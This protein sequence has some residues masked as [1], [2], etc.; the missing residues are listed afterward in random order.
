LLTIV[1][2]GCSPSSPPA[3]R[4][5][6]FPAAAAPATE[7]IAA[8]A[9]A[10][11]DPDANAF[12]KT[13]LAA[14]EVE[15]RLAAIN[16]LAGFRDVAHL[17][18]ILDQYADT[19]PRIRLAALQA[20]R[21]LGARGSLAWWDKARRDPDA[22]IRKEA[23][24]AVVAF[25]DENA[26]LLMLVAALDDP[27]PL[28]ADAATAALLK[29]G[30]QLVPLFQQLAVTAT[31]AARLRMVRL[32][33]EQRDPELAPSLVWIERTA[34][35]DE[36]LRAEVAR[37]LAALGPV[38]GEMIALG[39]A[40]PPA[41]LGAG[42]TPQPDCNV[43]VRLENGVK[44]RALVL[45]LD[46][47]DNRWPVT[48]WGYAP[49]FNKSDH[50]FTVLA[51]SRTDNLI[52]L[53][54][55]G[56]I[57]DDPWV[58]GGP[59]RYTMQFAGTNGTW[60]GLFRGQ[61]VSGVVQVA[62][63]PPL[64]VTRS[65]PP[66]R[67]QEHPRLGARRADWQPPTNWTFSAQADAALESAMQPRLPALN[68]E[69][70]CSA[71][72]MAQA[73]DTLY[74][75]ASPG[76]RRYATEAMLGMARGLLFAPSGQSTPWH[77]WQGRWRGGAGIAAIVALND[78]APFPLTPPSD[79]PVTECAPSAEAPDL[80]VN[81]LGDGPLAQWR[82]VG[83]ESHCV[84]RVS[85]PA[86]VR[87]K[88]AF[89][90]AAW[91]GDSHLPRD[92]LVALVPGAYLLRAVVTPGAR[93]SNEEWQP[94]ELVVVTDPRHRRAKWRAEFARWQI[95]GGVSPL[96]E[97][98]VKLAEINCRRY[99]EWA[100]GDGGFNAEKEK[101]TLCTVAEMSP[102]LHAL[103]N[104]LGRNLVAGSHAEW[105]PL[106][107]KAGSYG[108]HGG[109]QFYG[110][111]EIVDLMSQPMRQGLQARTPA[112]F[113]SHGVRDRQKTGYVFRNGWR[114]DAEDIFV[115]VEG[116]GQHLRSAH[117]SFD[118]GTF[119]LFGLGAAWAVYT[120]YGRDAPRDVHNV[121]LFPED[122]VD[123]TLPARE[124]HY[125]V[126][127][128]GSGTVS[129]DMND[130]YRGLGTETG[131]LTDFEARLIPA[132]V[133]DLGIKGVRAVAADFTGNSGAPGIVLVADKITGGGKRVW[134]MHLAPGVTAE[135]D[136]R[137]FTLRSKKTA[138]TVRGTFVVPS[139]VQLAGGG[140]LTA[141]GRSDFVV[142]MTL[143]RGIP[144]V[145]K[146][147]GDTIMVGEQVY[148]WEGT[149]IRF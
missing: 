93:M 135:I 60:H 136:G 131:Q 82:A 36:T 29:Q 49:N 115:T 79:E 71:I 99:F 5:P 9:R 37:L 22:G 120:S 23:L 140:T 27:E 114:G 67:Y 6:T 43:R 98:Y 69:W 13:C 141:T 47:R 116:K 81:V 7:R 24:L 59:A 101:Y 144:P 139:D 96:A 102:F 41:G 14:P 8:I 134:Q 142:V 32:L 89:D 45:D 4:P 104:C 90:T 97:R 94:P 38:A 19:D 128:E 46:C 149:Q 113:P 55:D 126:Q 17:R 63:S 44:D 137:T 88:L 83:V 106:R 109:A 121:V 1:L 31:S 18:L 28:I 48:A 148:H 51:A 16:Q 20:G 130:V 73:Y 132:R 125:A 87:V 66:L 138:A 122:G 118:T 57:A 42:T 68:V 85:F 143:Q 117:T 56:A 105:I 40:P 129:L 103:D 112:E 12:L 74:W 15:V 75:R 84:L 133:R 34:P 108:D 107:A 72:E 50:E 65:V 145:V 95:S 25:G 91:L 111:E 21:Q 127:P 61:S 86:T 80:P 146:M 76:M 70:A 123:G 33:A 54:V 53:E 110:G 124:I 77:N 30:R 35:G 78:P 26:G 11:N 119:R 52:K 92:G 2:T 10:N 3:P 147:E 39:T 64:P 58:S 100:I 62:V